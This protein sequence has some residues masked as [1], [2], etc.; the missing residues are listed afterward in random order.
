MSDRSQSVAS[1]RFSHIFLSTGFSSLGTG[2]K[3]LCFAGGQKGKRLLRGD[4]GHIQH[5]FNPVQATL[6][7]LQGELAAR[8]SAEAGLR[9][10]VSRLTEETTLLRELGE[11][12]DATAVCAVGGE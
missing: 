11:A 8:E 6:E 12:G 3:C 9:L 2:R 1:Y 5:D 4:G 10:E 7:R